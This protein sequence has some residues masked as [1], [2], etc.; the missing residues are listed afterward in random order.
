MIGVA[1]CF[2]SRKHKLTHGSL[3]VGK[4]E[5]T[6]VQFTKWK[7]TVALVVVNVKFLAIPYFSAGIIITYG[8]RFILRRYVV[9]HCA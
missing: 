7:S 3:F 2:I 5:F 6:F 1:G 4:N 8:G 9:W